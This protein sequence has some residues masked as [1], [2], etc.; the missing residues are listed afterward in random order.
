[1]NILF[2]VKVKILVPINLQYVGL[3]SVLTIESKMVNKF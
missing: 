2:N 3:L 1:M